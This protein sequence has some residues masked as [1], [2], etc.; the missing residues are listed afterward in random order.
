MW[1]YLFEIIDESGVK[2]NEIP[3]ILEADNFEDRQIES[4]EIIRIL[5]KLCNG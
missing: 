2:V 3:V 5:T 1:T 4:A